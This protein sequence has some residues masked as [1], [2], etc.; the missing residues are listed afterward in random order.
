MADVLGK[1]NDLQ[2]NTLAARTS[3]PIGALSAVM[4]SLEMKGVVKLTAGG[5][6][7]LIKN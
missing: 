1:D 7:H 4:F 5:V 3:I 6:Y 2:V